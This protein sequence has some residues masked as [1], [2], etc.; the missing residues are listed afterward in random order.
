MRETRTK[1]GP[2]LIAPIERAAMILRKMLTD[3]IAGSS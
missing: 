1:L 2:G 3:D